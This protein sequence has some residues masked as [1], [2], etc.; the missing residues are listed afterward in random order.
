M[1]MTRCV[2]ESSD[3][4]T[5]LCDQSVW[6]KSNMPGWVVSTAGEFLLLQA[7]FEN[8]NRDDMCSHCKKIAMTRDPKDCYI[9][10]TYEY[11]YKKYGIVK[12]PP[13]SR[14]GQL[15]ENQQ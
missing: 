2:I 12:A 15:G 10:L 13:P 4:G 9:L 3:S 5:T 14:L 8:P 7:Y 6:R 11:Y 1:D